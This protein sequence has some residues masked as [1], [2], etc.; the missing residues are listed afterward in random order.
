L[1]VVTDARFAVRRATSED[2]GT[3]SGMTAASRRRLAAWSPRWWNPS[4][5]ADALH[6]QWLRYLVESAAATV[7]VV[8]DDTVGVVGCA[9]SLRQSDQWVIDDVAV[10]DDRLLTT[11]GRV[12]L[13]SVDERPALLCVPTAD[14]PR[15]A[16]CAD[17]GLWVV[18]SYWICETTASHAA[19]TLPAVVPEGIPA[20]PPH[21][22]P[23]TGSGRDGELVVVGD[24][25]VVLGSPSLPPP[26]VYDPGGTVC[27]V[28]RVVGTGADDRAT[29]VRRALAAAGVRG[30]VIVAI[31]VGAADDELASVVAGVGFTRIVDVRAWP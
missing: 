28:D 15:A 27:I 24:A 18:S 4:A 13:Q 10:A 2:V 16:T 6:P 21:T 31:V 5:G 26:P 1:R 22:F 8:E 7:R 19:D 14:E 23:P 30:D 20:A 29:L 9:V 3:I 12:L 25:G 17:V 11:A